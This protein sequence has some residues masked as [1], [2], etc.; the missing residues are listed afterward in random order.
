MAERKLQCSIHDGQVTA[1]LIF[2]DV[3]GA[4]LLVVYRNRSDTDASLHIRNSEFETPL[5][6]RI[7]MP[8]QANTDASLAIRPGAYFMTRAD[9]GEWALPEG[10]TFG[11]SAMR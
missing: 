1:S 7:E 2:D 8:K 5:K 10:F 3:T 11:A 6:Q 4:I 9:D